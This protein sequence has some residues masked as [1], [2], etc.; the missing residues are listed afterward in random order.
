MT[1]K[2]S[3]SETRMPAKIIGA[4]LGTTTRRKIAAREAP[5]FCADQTRIQGA[6][7]AP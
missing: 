5:M 7:F 2:E 6:P 3:A 1:M 4:A